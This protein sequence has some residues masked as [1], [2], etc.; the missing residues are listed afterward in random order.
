MKRITTLLMGAGALAL[1]ACSGGDEGSN[2]AAANAAAENA[3]ANVIFGDT[4]SSG[5]VAEEG[6]GNTMAAQP[7]APAA[8][9]PAVRRPNTAPKAAPA[10][11]RE[12]PNEATPRPAP[13]PEPSP[14][15]KT[16]C[17]P[18]HRAAGHC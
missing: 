6:E 17:A 15:P 10:P 7:A 9:A 18:E 4:N 3:S 14:P 8:P 11:R 5:D 12:Q 1:A 2:N 16:D 13:T